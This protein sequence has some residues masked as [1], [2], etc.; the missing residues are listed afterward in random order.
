MA[1]LMTGDGDGNFIDLYDEEVMQF[2]IDVCDKIESAKCDYK[3]NDQTYGCD[4]PSK[5][6]VVPSSHKC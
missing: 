4:H 5:K 3:F 6:L 1:E 2:V